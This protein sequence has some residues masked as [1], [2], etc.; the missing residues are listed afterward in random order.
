MK[1]ISDFDAFLQDTVNL[2]QSRIDKL[3]SRVDAIESFL[4]A[5]D[6][7]DMFIGLIPAGSWAHNTIIKPVAGNDT[8]DADVLLLLKE[9][10]AWDAKEYLER[11]HS[12]FS[13]SST[14]KRLVGRTPKTRCVRVNYADEFHI[15]IVPYLERHGSNYITNRLEPPATGR[16]ELSDPES[17]TQWVDARQRITGGQFVK[18]VRMMK[19]LR[20]HKNTFSCKSIILK[21]LLGEAIIEIDDLLDPN[22]YRDLPT[23]LRTVVR[24]FADALPGTMPAVLDPAGTGDNFTDRYREDWNYDNFRKCML[25]YADKIDQAFHED[26]RDKSIILWREIFGQQFKSVDS[27][28]TKSGGGLSASQAYPAEMF[29][30]KAPMGFPIR[31]SRTDR[32]KLEGRV[33]GLKSGQ[34]SR[35]N[36]FRVFTLSAN[37]NRVPKNRSLRFKASTNVSRP[38]DMYWKVRNGGLEATQANAQRGEIRKDQGEG[39]RVES[40]LFRGYHYVEVYVVKGGCVVAKD[41]QSVIVT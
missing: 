24:K 9:D 41:K 40:S 5:S 33:T 19:Y 16:F 32:V 38:Y 6:I 11:V 37:G 22:C 14:Y 39:V 34:I 21:T 31:L 4:G 3:Q 2:N 13:G 12:T 29:I 8:F 25:S 23:T 26:D 18:V 15:D 7:A 36:G 27:A 20:D 10:P 1:F 17:F 30:D 28:T 35:R